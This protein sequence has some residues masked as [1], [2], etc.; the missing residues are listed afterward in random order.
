MKFDMEELRKGINKKVDAS[1]LETGKLNSLSIRPVAFDVSG[2]YLLGA[3]EVQFPDG[4]VMVSVAVGA[5]LVKGVPVSMNMY[6]DYEGT[7][8]MLAMVEEQ[9]KNLARLDAANP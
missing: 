8:A 7:A 3:S 1:G 4:K 5:T 6:R 2:A 9:K